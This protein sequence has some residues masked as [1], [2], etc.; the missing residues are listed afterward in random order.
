MDVNSLNEMIQECETMINTLTKRLAAL[1]Q[2][3]PNAL[4]Q[5]LGTYQPAA[6]IRDEVDKYKQMIVDELQKRS[7]ELSGLSTQTLQMMQQQLMSSRSSPLSIDMLNQ[8]A[9][10]N[11]GFSE[12][13]S[14]NFGGISVEKFAE[15][16][17]QASGESKK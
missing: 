7:A 10:G 15:A 17:R 16:L 11:N 1:K 2:M 13:I 8:V 9:T 4:A 14:K 12:A 3:L 5:D 6:S